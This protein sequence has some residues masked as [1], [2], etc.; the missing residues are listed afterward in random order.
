MEKVEG[1]VVK[2]IIFTATDP[3]ALYKSIG[4]LCE[5]IKIRSDTEHKLFVS[6]L[7]NHTYLVSMGCVDTDGERHF[8][9]NHEAI[10]IPAN[11]VGE[12]MRL[13]Q[14]KNVYAKTNC[15]MFVGET[16]EKQKRVNDLIDW[17]LEIKEDIGI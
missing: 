8:I 1:D 9:G 3:E 7:M 12:I 17:L 4:L 2:T 11:R 5:T 10:F 6:P 14:T 15:M 16:E 13:E